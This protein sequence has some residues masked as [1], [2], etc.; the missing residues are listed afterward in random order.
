M[1][2]GYCI[3]SSVHSYLRSISTAVL[4]SLSSHSISIS[5]FTSCFMNIVGRGFY[6]TI[7]RLIFYRWREF[8]VITSFD[9]W[10]NPSGGVIGR[11][12][13]TGSSD[14]I[15]RLFR[16]SVN[17]DGGRRT[18]GGGRRRLGL[19]LIAYKINKQTPYENQDEI[20]WI[21]TTVICC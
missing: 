3:S 4:A 10:F 5:I 21:W 12:H 19:V 8:G 15:L 14:N 11:G 1:D 7:Y 2:C 18:A 6:L 16:P 13:R 9:L 20:Y 17:I